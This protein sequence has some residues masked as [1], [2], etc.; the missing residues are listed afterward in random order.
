VL[1]AEGFAVTRLPV[2]DQGRISPAALQAALARQP[3]ALVSLALC[4]HE[5]GNLYPIAELSALAHAAG[6]LFHCDAVQ[7]AGRMPVDVRALG[8]DLLTLSGHK[9]AGPK[10]VG[11]L[12]CRSLP[13][14]PPLA[15]II[16]GGQQEKGRRAGTENVLGI[17]GL[18]RACALAQSDFLPAAGRVAA[19]RDRLEKG[20]LA[21]PGARRHGDPGA[22]VPGTANLAFAGVEGELLFMNLD[23]AG[24]A[25]STGAA[26]SSGSPEPSPV[27]RALGLDPAAALE[28]VRFS[29]GPTN[30]EAEVDAVI[31]LVVRT[32][33]HIR[34]LSPSPPHARQPIGPNG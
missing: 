9:L 5:L 23:L 28:A 25:I 22:R 4:N 29:L 30:S 2:D 21:V 32:V 3:A 13:S 24:V 8:I 7:A 27:L 10:G 16:V 19:L 14:E 11:A 18:G 1:A 20:L 6:A 17:V 31:A 33:A 34:G 26:C 12:Y 15:P